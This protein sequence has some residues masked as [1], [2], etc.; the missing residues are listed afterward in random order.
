[1]NPGEWDGVMSDDMHDACLEIFRSPDAQFPHLNVGVVLLKPGT[2]V[3]SWAESEAPN[4]TYD[5]YCKPDPDTFEPIT[6]AGESGLVQ[7]VPCVGAFKVSNVYLVHDDQGI[8]LSWV[9]VGLPSQTF[10]SIL[11]SLQLP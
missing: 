4:T 11:E 10:M 1:M 8:L 5:D 6:V 9:G 7:N 2:T 3:E